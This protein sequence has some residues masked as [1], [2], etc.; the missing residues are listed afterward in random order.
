EYSTWR[1]LTTKVVRMITII[2]AW[3][4]T[5]PDAMNCADPANTK[6]DMPMV[7]AG[8]SPF[9]TE[10]APKIIANG[11]APT[12]RGN[13]SLT[14]AQNSVWR[15]GSSTVAILVFTPDA[16]GV[17]IDHRRFYCDFKAE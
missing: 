10:A 11:V 2:L 17:K 6:A 12:T 4:A 5:S 7:P 9:G 8:D 1:R 3:L 13:V 15:V 16:A 14:P